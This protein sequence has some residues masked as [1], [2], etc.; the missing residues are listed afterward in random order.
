MIRCVALWLACFVCSFAYS[1]T[2]P[3]CPSVFQSNVDQI[4]ASEQYL[5][6]LPCAAG[7]PPRPSSANRQ[8]YRDK[9]KKSK[10]KNRYFN[11]FKP[12]FRKNCVYL[13]G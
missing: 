13:N 7:L 5:S 12:V 8:G 6:V 9:G 10:Q 2:Q 11:A 1:S 4:D 3:I